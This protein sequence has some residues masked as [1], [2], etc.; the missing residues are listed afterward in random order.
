MIILSPIL[1]FSKY[2][3]LNNADCRVII[4]DTLLMCF[5]HMYSEHSPTLEMNTD[6]N[7]D[8]TILLQLINML[9]VQRLLSAKVKS[10]VLQNEIC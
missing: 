4:R 5:I 9:V 1:Y 10:F 3:F 2:L 6:N 8:D 7:Y